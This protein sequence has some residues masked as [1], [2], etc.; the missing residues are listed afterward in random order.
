[1]NL[2][3]NKMFVFPNLQEQVSNT[4]ELYSLS[5]PVLLFKLCFFLINFFRFSIFFN[6][7]AHGFKEKESNI[8]FQSQNKKIKLI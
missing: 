4:Y 5:L 3:D 8:F 6:K 7:L 1:M 2:H